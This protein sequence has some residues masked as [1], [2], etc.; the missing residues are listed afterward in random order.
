[1]FVEVQPGYFV[2]AEGRVFSARRRTLVELKPQR[3]RH[4]YLTVVINHKREYIHRL[5]L[6]AF[7]GPAKPKQEARHLDGDRAH[8]ALFN[9]AWSTRAE[10]HADKIKHG[11][12]QIGSRNGSAVLTDSDIPQIH[13]RYMAGET[14]KSIAERFNV[15]RRT[16]QDI[17]HGRR[18]TH[19]EVANA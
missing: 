16:I 9:L 12:H 15:G 3:V 13:N 2:N 14:I 19:I 17:V 10:N 7:V 11:T 8:N 18:W 1:M 6:R 5:V 4:G